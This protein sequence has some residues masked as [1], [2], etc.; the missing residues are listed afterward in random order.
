MSIK[1]LDPPRSGFYII[2]LSYLAVIG[3]LVWGAEQPRL[4]RAFEVLAR[5]DRGNFSGYSEDDIK[6]LRRVL[7][8]YSGFSRALV[9]RSSAKFLEPR[10]DG[11]LK[12]PH[13]HL[14][15]RPDKGKP[16]V[17]LLESEGSP[18]DYPVTVKIAGK[19]FEK[20][21][22][23]TSNAPVHIELSPTEV[24]KTSILKFD[25]MTAGRRQPSPSWGLR[26]SAL[27][28]NRDTQ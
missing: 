17:L 13:A 1:T 5:R 27:I 8:D 4:D 11:W 23:V 7:D 3:F 9:G 25:V 21:L 2:V 16:T 6:F 12:T 18:S 28:T 14:A 24:T 10:V 26:L 15:V 19:G 22:N 20:T